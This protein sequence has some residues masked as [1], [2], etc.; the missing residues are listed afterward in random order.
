MADSDGNMAS[1]QKNRSSRRTLW[2]GLVPAGIT[3][4]LAVLTTLCIRQSADEQSYRYAQGLFQSAWDRKFSENRYHFEQTF[5]LTYDSLRTIAMLPCVREAG[6]GSRQLSDSSRSTLQQLYN[7]IASHVA[8]AEI[9]ITP[10]PA[11]SSD[12]NQSAGQIS[13]Q[14]TGQLSGPMLRMDRIIIDNSD[15][16]SAEAESLADAQPGNTPRVTREVGQEMLEQMR[17]F[18]L[19]FGDALQFDGMAYPALGSAV[20]HTNDKGATG[21]VYS[22]PFYNTDGSLGGVVSAILPTGTIASAL[23]ERY[24][25]AVRSA[26]DCTILATNADAHFAASVPQLRTGQP[27]KGFAYSQTF[28]SGLTDCVPWQVIAAVPDSEL[29]AY[30]VLRAGAV[31]SRMIF[32]GG[33]G[34]SVLLAIIVW[35]FCSTHDRAVRLAK[36]MTAELGESERRFRTLVG[37]IPGAVYR[38]RLDEGAALEYVS[39]SIQDI[40]GYPPSA[41]LGENARTIRTMVIPADQLAIE[42]AEQ[43]AVATREPLNIEYRIQN[44]AGETRWVHEQG[45]ASL[46]GAGDHRYLEGIIFDITAQKFAEAER[47]RMQKRVVELSRQAGMADVATGVL[48]NVGNV[49]NSVNVSAEAIRDKLKVSQLTNLSRASSMMDEHRET[50]ASFLTTDEKGK[51]LPGFI[52]KVTASLHKEHEAIEE[53]LVHLGKSIEHIRQI[54]TAQQSYAK[55]NVACQSVDLREILEDAVRINLPSFSRHGVELVR[56]YENIPQVVADKHLIMQILVNLIGNAKHAVSHNGRDEKRITLRMEVFEREGTRRARIAVRD[57]GVG[58]APENLAKIFVHGFT[59]KKE[60]HGFGLHSAANAAAQMHGSL[61]VASD[62]VGHGAEF[63]L[64]LPL[65][66][67]GQEPAEHAEAGVALATN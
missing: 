22:V 57:T 39:A 32:Y 4:I 36:K 15:T 25:A 54:V 18:N 16:L 5:N 60:G 64:D 11:S 30:P 10:V 62:G 51:R 66:P 33:L 17:L 35:S 13:G 67:I 45:R 48:H 53:E 42:E 46:Q 41:F 14:L 9:D 23:G 63:R 37:N 29:Q 50:L 1:T 26:T 65:A 21:I 12:A 52:S 56:Q 27:V 55:P 61:T 2:T 19:H 49:L 44:A 24:F 3:L 58:I 59:T 40:T 43:I 28:T 20:V 6:A 34:G 47:D 38:M 31:R 7:D 8:L